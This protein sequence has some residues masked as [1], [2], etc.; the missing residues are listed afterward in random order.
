MWGKGI[1]IYCG[2]SDKV[3]PFSVPSE[4]GKYT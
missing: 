3:V 1:L 4:G 2:L